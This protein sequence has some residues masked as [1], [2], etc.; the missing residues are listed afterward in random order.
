MPDELASDQPNLSGKGPLLNPDWRSIAD[1]AA[2]L[3]VHTS[4]LFRWARRGVRGHRLRLTRIG[5]RTGVTSAD[6]RALIRNV[7][8]EPTAEAALGGRGV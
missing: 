7:N 5:G 6:L 3:G 2:E 8:A 4:T 1:A